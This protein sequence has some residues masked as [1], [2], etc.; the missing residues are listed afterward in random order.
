MNVV[1]GTI[2]GLSTR[3][4]MITAFP[5]GTGKQVARELSEQNDDGSFRVLKREIFEDHEA[6]EARLEE[7]RKTGQPIWGETP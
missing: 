7:E 6:Y 2:S 1:S 4:Q 5:Y 3:S